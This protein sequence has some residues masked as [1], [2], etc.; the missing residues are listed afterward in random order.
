[1]AQKMTSFLK[2]V[3]EYVYPVLDKSAFLERYVQASPPSLPP[4]LPP[5]FPLSMLP[6]AMTTLSSLDF[7]V[8]VR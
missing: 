4:L 8:A 6:P 1:M 5:S 2:G 3:R 7:D